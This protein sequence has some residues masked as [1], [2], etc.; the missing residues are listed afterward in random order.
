MLGVHRQHARQR[1][2]AEAQVDVGVVLE[3]PEV[4]LRRQREQRLALGRRERVPG[5]VLEVGDD[6][7]Q[8]R[9][10]CLRSA[11]A[12]RRARP[13]RSR[14]AAARPRAPSRRARAATAACGHTSGAPRS[15]RRRAPRAA[16]TGTR[17]PASSRWSRA[18]APAPPRGD[19][20]STPATAGSRPRCRRR[21]CPPGRSRTRGPP[22]RADRPRRRCRATAR[23]V[24]MRSLGPRVCLA[25]RRSLG[26]RAARHIPGSA[27]SR[28][29]PTDRGSATAPRRSAS[30]LR[31]GEETSVVARV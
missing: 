7:R 23:R 4:V 15:P 20:R 8:L 16:R 13:C 9:L 28:S 25:R 5:G 2:A 24:R 22:R 10:H 11:A 18:H 30:W 26:V 19:P 3:H 29:A 27:P 6:V 21:W 31:E 1:L 17:R 12:G 14:P